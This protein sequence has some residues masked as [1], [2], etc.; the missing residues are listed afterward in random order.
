MR[1]VLHIYLSAITLLFANTGLTDVENGGEQ[2]VNPVLIEHHLALVPGSSDWE[3]TSTEPSFM[4]MR[5]SD[6]SKPRRIVVVDAAGR[7]QRQC[8]GVTP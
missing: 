6:L 8:T 5:I 4:V 3:A 2:R 1:Y 7:H